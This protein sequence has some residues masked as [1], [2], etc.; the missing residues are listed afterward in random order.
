MI[1]AAYGIFY[2]IIPYQPAL[3]SVPFIVSE[4]SYTNPANVSDP[5][6]VQWPLAFPNVQRLAGVS[7]PSTYENGFRTGYAQ[8]WN[9]TLEKELFQTSF[10]GSV[11][12]HGR[13]PV[14]ASV[15]CE[16][17]AA[18]ARAFCR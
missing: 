18:R 2:D 14:P 17:A 12:R 4:P 11:Y 10:R 1:R 9:F 6:F 7:V 13:A 5:G 16:P 8:N 15:Q 3:F